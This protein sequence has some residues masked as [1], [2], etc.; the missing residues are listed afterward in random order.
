MTTLT[1]KLS[2]ICSGGN[3]LTFTISGDKSA[4]VQAMPSDLSEPISNE[5]ALAF[6]KVLAR[7]AKAGRTLAQ[8]RALL[9]S[10]V[11]GSV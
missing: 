11:T 5:D 1:L 10:G 9:Q 6:C 8:A 2:A 3:H 4:T 7:M